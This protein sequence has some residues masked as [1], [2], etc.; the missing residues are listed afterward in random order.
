[1]TTKTPR[2]YSDLA[3]PPGETLAEELEVRGMS[4]RELAARLGRPAQVINEIIRGKKAITP[5]TAIGLAKVLGIEAQFWINLEADYQM[6][7]ALLRDKEALAAQEQ[8]LSEYPVREMI[9]RGWIDAGRDKASRLKALL[10]F[11]EVASIQPKVY[12]EAV[13]FRITEAAQQKVSTGALAVWL[14]QG[15]IEAERIDTADY[16]EQRFRDALVEIRG[17]TELSPDKFHPAMTT[18]CA[19]AGVAF[20]VVQELPKI[21]ANGVARWMTDRKALIQMSIRN[22][23]ADIFWFSFFHEADH[24]LEHRTQ[25]R[26]LIDGLEADPAMAEIEAEADQFARDFLIAPEDW[27]AFCDESCFTLPAVSEF[28]QSVGIA[29]FVVV[30]RLQKE[31]KLRYDQLAELKLRYGWVSR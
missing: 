11:F 6:T 25:R 20:C 2:V 10:N 30:G 4:Q 17:L 3:I 29:A 28:A 21:G 26:I 14:R 8:W 13:G 22:K 18:L 7:L 19:E 23:W 15:E 27:N 5:D 12:Q 24:L 31:G 9:K 16:D 1:M